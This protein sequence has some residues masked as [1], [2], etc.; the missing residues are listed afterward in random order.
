MGTATSASVHD[1]FISYAREDKARVKQLVHALT[2]SRG[3][4]IWW[5]AALRPGAQFPREIEA[6]LAS[7]RCVLVVWSRHSIAS[8]WVVAE[9]SE[10]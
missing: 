5:D 6:T 9:A 7:A 3:W 1:V 10:G 2:A 8:D 4:S